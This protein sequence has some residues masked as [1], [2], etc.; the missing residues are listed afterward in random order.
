[1]EPPAPERLW[2]HVYTEP[3]A[4]VDEERDAYLAYLDSFADAEETV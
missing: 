1:M 3:H 2:E 4:L